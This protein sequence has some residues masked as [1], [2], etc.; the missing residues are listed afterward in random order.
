MLDL[1]SP[2]PLPLPLPPY[3]VSQSIPETSGASASAGDNGTM[4]EYAGEYPMP[5]SARF[6]SGSGG[7]VSLASHSHTLNTPSR[8]PSTVARRSVIGGSSRLRG[9]LPVDDSCFNAQTC[10]VCGPRQSYPWVSVGEQP[11]RD[12]HQHQHQQPGKGIRGAATYMVCTKCKLVRYCSAA[13]QQVHWAYHKHWCRP[14]LTLVPQL[15]FG[16]RGWAGLDNLGNSCYMNSGVQALAHMLPLTRLLVSGQYQGEVNFKNA[17]G[18]GGALV[19]AYSDLLQRMWLDGK[20]SVRPTGLRTIMG[21]KVNPDYSRL[22][23]QVIMKH[24]HAYDVFSYL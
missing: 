19:K 21:Q 13:C 7:A 24:M 12:Q 8:P 22:A 2:P 9:A 1:T 17:D 14:A 3:S 18:T 16:R 23:Q 20:S 5:M 4:G 15:Q 11:Q 10:F 6:A